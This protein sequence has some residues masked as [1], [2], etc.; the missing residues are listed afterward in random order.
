MK[1]LKLSKDDAFL[2]SCVACAGLFFFALLAAVDRSIFPS[3]GFFLSL[4]LYL[5][6][7]WLS[8]R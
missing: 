5:V 3:I 6:T 8:D 2:A 4:A 7:T 1:K